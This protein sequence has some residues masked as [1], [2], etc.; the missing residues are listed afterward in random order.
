MP[1]PGRAI[2]RLR[3]H[4]TGEATPQVLSPHEYHCEKQH[5]AIDDRAD[6]Q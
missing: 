5:G 6:G 2:A 3:T 4:A 1:S